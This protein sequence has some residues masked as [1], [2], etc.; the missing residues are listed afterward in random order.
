MLSGAGDTGSLSICNMKGNRMGKLVVSCIAVGEIETNCYLLHAEGAEETLIVDPG[1]EARRIRKKMETEGLRPV[2]ILLTHGHYDHTL[3]VGTLRRMYPGIPV[4]ACLDEKDILL[5]PSLNAWFMDRF[6]PVTADIWLKEG[7]ELDLA[8]L[9][10]RVLQT[11]G[12]TIGS[13]CFYFEED[14]VL[15]AGDTLFFTGYGRT[16]LPTGSARQLKK[17]LERLLL[18]LPGDVIVLPGHGRSTT[19]GFEKSVEGLG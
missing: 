13:I 8:G 12:H 4:Y 3:A 10:C 19:I 5:D 2:A 16:D 14:K 17:S 15:V 11:P 7:D 6:E 9:H 1:G 18:T